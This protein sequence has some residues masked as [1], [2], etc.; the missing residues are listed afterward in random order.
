M[1]HELS[2]G[3][4]G[5]G[6]HPL[7]RPRGRRRDKDGGVPQL[8]GAGTTPD[9]RVCHLAPAGWFSYRGVSGFHKVNS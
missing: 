1:G 4:V 2:A 7:I 5:C 8:G 6:P 9:T 3:E